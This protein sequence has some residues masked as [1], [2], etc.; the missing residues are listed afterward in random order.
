LLRS[1]LHACLSGREY[2]IATTYAR[3]MRGKAGRMR[4]YSSIMDALLFTGGDA[5]VR[6]EE[7]LEGHPFACAADSGLLTAMRWGVVPDLVVGDM[8]SLADPSLLDSLPPSSV[9]RF[10]RD[11]DETDTEIGLRV[12]AERGFREVALIGGGGGRLDHLLAILALFERETRP[13][14]WLTARERIDFVDGEILFP[15]ERG[16]TV[17]VFPV[18]CGQIRTESEGLRWKLDGLAWKRGSFGVSNEASAHAVRI[19]VTA[20]AVLVVRKLPPLPVGSDR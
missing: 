6:I 19:T 1:P 8:D 13:S 14:T 15:A 7:M 12:L 16:D 20:G 5:P 17:S 9:I 11:K 4:I 3:T 10:P 18:G 2:G